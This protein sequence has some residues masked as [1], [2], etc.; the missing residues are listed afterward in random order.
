M[1]DS[2]AYIVMFL[3]VWSLDLLVNMINSGR[4]ASIPRIKLDDRIPFLPLFIYFYSLYFPLI[5]IPLA[6]LFSAPRLL[7]RYLISSILVMAIS[8]AIFLVF[9]TKLIRISIQADS[10]SRKLTL[11]F[12]RI[13][14][15]YNLL[16]SMH[17]SMLV[18]A[19][20]ILLV[21]RR[22]YAW[23]LSTPIGLSILSVIFTKQHYILDLIAAVPLAVFAFLASATIQGWTH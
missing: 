17:V 6:I 20:L 11:F 16:P 1:R 23:I 15:P 2:F 21:H 9:P 22:P 4:A 5:M 18:L 14:A 13:V 12:H 3:G 8:Y 7:Q 10:F 19:F